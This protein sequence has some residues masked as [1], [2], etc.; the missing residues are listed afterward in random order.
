MSDHFSDYDKATQRHIIELGCFIHAKSLE[1]NRENHLPPS[2][3]V[4]DAINI[5][6]LNKKIRPPPLKPK[7][8]WYY[9]LCEDKSK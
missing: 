5:V 6:H 8:K 2:P 4:P 7:N 3:P 1:Y 9:S